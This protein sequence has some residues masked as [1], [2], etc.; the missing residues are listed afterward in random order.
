LNQGSF[1]MGATSPVMMLLQP[2]VNQVAA[3]LNMSPQIA[4]VVA[5]IALHYLLSSHSSTS[6]NAPLNLGSVM[7]QLSRGGVSQGT[8]RNSGMVNDVMSAT[9]LNKQQAVKTLETTFGA[10]GAGVQGQAN[11]RRG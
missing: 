2:V 8:L 7:Q 4:T 9:G 5:S 6:P 10:M 1:N 3:K 11:L